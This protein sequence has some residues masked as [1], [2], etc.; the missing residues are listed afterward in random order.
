V[1]RSE[2]TLH[3]LSPV[4]RG[5]H[6]RNRMHHSILGRAPLYSRPRRAVPRGSNRPEGDGLW[7]ERRI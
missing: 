7:V 2:A 4:G 3:R 6:H 1:K 5:Y